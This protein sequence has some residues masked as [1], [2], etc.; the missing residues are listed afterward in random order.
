MT[1]ITRESIEDIPTLG[2][3]G[4][5][6]HS[7]PAAQAAGRRPR[8]GDVAWC[9]HVSRGSTFPSTMAAVSSGVPICQTCQQTRREAQKEGPDAKA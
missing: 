3:D 2:D 1:T 5:E 4:R 7:Y 9:G 8:A 6:L